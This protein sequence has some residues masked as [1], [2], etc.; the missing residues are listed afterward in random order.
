MKKLLKKI[1]KL[2]KM[3]WTFPFDESYSEAMEDMIYDSY[4]Y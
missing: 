1:W 2:L 4:R 3:M